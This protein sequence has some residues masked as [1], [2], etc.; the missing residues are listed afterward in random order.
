M[1][2]FFKWARQPRFFN[3]CQSRRLSQFTSTR[4]VLSRSLTK[5]DREGIHSLRQK[6][7]H[8]PRQDSQEGIWEV[9]AKEFW[10]LLG[11]QKY[12]QDAIRFE[13][14]DICVDLKLKTFDAEHFG[15][16]YYLHD[17]FILS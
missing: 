17:N 13:K 15:I 6:N 1:L 4:R 5:E 12:R 11:S 7:L 3:V 10:P 14:K 9:D 2:L 8:G 16:N